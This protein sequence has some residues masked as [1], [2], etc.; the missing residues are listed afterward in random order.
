MAHPLILRSAITLTFVVIVSFFAMACHEKQH[1]LAMSPCIPLNGTTPNAT[2]RTITTTYIYADG[3]LLARII[4][5][6]TGTCI[7]YVVQ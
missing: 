6:S 7:Q 4:R 3:Q 5:N 1:S 2:V